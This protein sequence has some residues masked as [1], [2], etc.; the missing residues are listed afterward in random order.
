MSNQVKLVS[1]QEKKFVGL[2][3][4]SP[5][6]AHQ[7]ERIDEAK[8]IFI[9]RRHEI[10]AVVNPNEYV[11]P[12]YT[13]EVLFTYFFCMEVSEITDVPNGMIGF[14]LPAHTYALTRSD[15]DPYEVIHS[16][17]RDIGKESN[18]RALAMEIYSFDNPQWPSQVDVY[19]P[20][21][22]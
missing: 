12:H 13:S 2:P 6:E 18:Q 5:F 4:T 14:T 3:V 22:E 20:I 15:Q 16:F 11:C 19:L 17:L 21:K 1:L 9:E 7:P 10:K 8:Q